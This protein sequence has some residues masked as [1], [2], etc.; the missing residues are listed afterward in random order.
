MKSVILAAVAAMSVCAPAFASE[1]AVQTTT[2]TT[3]TTMTAVECKAE[4]DK[5]LDQACK[6]ALVAKGCLIAPAN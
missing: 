2:T 5:C 1:A 6:D 4:M 3:G